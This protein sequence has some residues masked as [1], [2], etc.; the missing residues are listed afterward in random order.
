MKNLQR[1]MLMNRG[2]ALANNSID[3]GA[4]LIYFIKTIC[5]LKAGTLDSAECQYVAVK[6]TTTKSS[7]P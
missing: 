2:Q 5:R 3:Q 4:V 7:I 1:L 6:N